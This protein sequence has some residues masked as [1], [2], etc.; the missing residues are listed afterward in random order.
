MKY[1]DVYEIDL[2]YYDNGGGA[3]EYDFIIA[4]G[5]DPNRIALSIEGAEQVKLVSG[6]LVK[7]STGEIR[8]HAPGY[9]KSRKRKEITGRYRMTNA[10]PGKQELAFALTL[11]TSN[12]L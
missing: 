6:D 7:A 12:L 9:R 10:E 8:Q 11:T 1:E 5:A 4:P 2:V 3:L